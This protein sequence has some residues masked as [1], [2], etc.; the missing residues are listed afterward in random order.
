MVYQADNLS[1]FYNDEVANVQAI[2][3]FF[4]N[5]AYKSDRYDLHYSSGVAVTWPSA[6]GWFLG[7]NMFASR[8]SC[9][10]FSWFLGL[11]LGF[12]FFRRNGYTNIASAATAVCLWGLTITSPLA[13]PYW[14]GFMYNLGELNAIIFIGFGLLLV[15]KYPWLSAFIFGIAVGHGKFTYLPLALAILMGDVLSRRLPV[16]KALFRFIGYLTVFLLPLLI[17]MVWLY[18]R[19]GI[20]TLKQWL[21]DQ[22]IWFSTNESFPEHGSS[23]QFSLDA[24]RVRLTSPKYEWVNYTL[25]TKLKNLL[26]SFGAIGLT[27]TGLIM[28][29]RKIP[30]VSNKEKWISIMANISII[31]YC[32]V[33]FLIHSYMW[34]RHFLPA[35]YIGFGLFLFWGVKLIE[36]YSFI[37]KTFFYSAA[38]FLIILQGIYSIKHPIILQPQSSYARSCTDLYSAKCDPTLYK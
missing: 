33:Y 12:L 10:F 25:G 28:V 26:F 38:I 8:I 19:F 7:H 5:R 29:E 21:F 36:N 11:L 32:I 6:I 35:V 9:A 27:L 16:R 15:S 17:W 31:F 37:S 30:S 1:P 13:L 23:V 14:F 2:T 22:F 24:L 18:L 34:Q 3:S 4:S 20:L